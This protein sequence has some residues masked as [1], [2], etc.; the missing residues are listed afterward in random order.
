MQTTEV[1]NPTEDPTPTTLSYPSGLNLFLIISSLSLSVFLCALDETIIS[2]A[3]P[4]ITNDF[5]SITDIVAPIATYCCKPLHI[6]W[7]GSAYFTTFAAF[8]LIYGKL[9]CFFFI[10]LVFLISV[11]IFEIGSLLCGTAVNSGMFIA[12]RA[13]AGLG[14]AGINAGF[15]IILAAS[16]PLERRPIFVSSYSGVYG[17]AAVVA[18]LLGG[19][20]T[21]KATWRW[22]FWV[23][24]PVGGVAVLLMVFFFH[25]VEE[26]KEKDRTW[27]EITGEM[28]LLETL[29]FVP[30][31]V[32]LLLALQ[33]G[34]T[35]YRWVDFRVLVPLVL[36]SVALL[37]F[38]GIQGWKQD[39]GTVPPRIFKQRSVA[40]S[41]VY[42]FCA[43]G[44]LNVF[45]YYL[46]L[47]FQAIQ[48]RNI[49]QSGF[50]ILPTT[51]GTVLLSLV[52]G[53]GV[54]KTGYY[55]PFMIVGAAFL[56]TGAALSTQWKVDSP[57]VQWIGVQIVISIG[58][59]LGVQQ[60]HTAAQTVLKTDVPTGTVIPGLDVNK[61]LDGGATSLRSLLSEDLLPMAMEAYNTA[62]TRGFLVAV[63]LAGR[64]LLV[65]LGMEWR[66]VKKSQSESISVD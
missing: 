25:P 16:L 66:S 5:N 20:F 42:V 32:G 1:I 21:D 11:L 4:Q 38:V 47:W 43:A 13:V 17:L 45:Q 27:K 14:S 30:G 9:F 2:N 63:S 12:G 57:V 15:I 34:G 35:V 23:N 37:G 41:S 58:A 52:A 10:K 29:V 28:D 50:C 55:T 26:E 19:L 56:L 7:Y 18:P 64:A 51:L 39:K 65:S 40:C 46:P 44:G 3:I 48:G 6:G 36:G 24:L 33:W 59:G 31:V 54:A 8:Q 60:A 49:L 53:V 22:C 62:F 61:I